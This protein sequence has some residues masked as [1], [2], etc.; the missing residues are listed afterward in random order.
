M[1][2]WIIWLLTLVLTISAV[3]YQRITGPTYPFK[4]NITLNNQTFKISIPRTCES[5]LD[6]EVTLN[7]PKEYSG[8]ISYRLYPSDDSYT[9]ISMNRENKNL[10]AYLPKQPPAGKLEYYIRIYKDNA[11]VYSTE[12]NPIHIRFKGRVPTLVLLFHILFMFTAML[13]STYA[14]FAALFKLDSQK[15]FGILT[16]I[17]L[18]I[19]GAIFGPIVQKHAFGAYWTGIPYGYDL[20]DN[21]TLIALIFWIIAVIANLKKPR[22]F[23]TVIAALVLIIIYSIPH[24]LF[25]SQLDYNTGEVTQG[26]IFFIMLKSKKWKSL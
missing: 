18:I 19:G 2:K 1:K 23:L 9:T 16:L 13:F 21:K 8:T 22:Y 26:I 14:G 24:S 20:T 6:A 3:I 5:D 25:G 12:Q 17:F 10:I 15:L 4:K 7:L 11:L